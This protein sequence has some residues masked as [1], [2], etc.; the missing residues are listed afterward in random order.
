MDSQLAAAPKDQYTSS[1]ADTTAFVDTSAHATADVETSADTVHKDYRLW[2]TSM[3]TKV[4]PVAV[5]QNGV[6]MTN[7]PPAGLKANM[8]LLSKCWPTSGMR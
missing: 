2:L 5:L 4:F 8:I 7:E 3:P 1:S 6:K